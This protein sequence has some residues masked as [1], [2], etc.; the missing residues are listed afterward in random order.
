MWGIQPR[1]K[2]NAC[3]RAESKKK[4]RE[5]EMKLIRSLKI[6]GTYNYTNKP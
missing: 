5:R 4:E 2:K 3:I 6:K 1:Q